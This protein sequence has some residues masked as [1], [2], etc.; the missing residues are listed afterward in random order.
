M[1]GDGELESCLVHL[2]RQTLRQYATTANIKANG[3]FECLIRQF[4]S[5]SEVAGK[6]GVPYKHCSHALK[7]AY[8]LRDDSDR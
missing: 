6:Y 7:K 1:V 8:T 4:P 5:A 2:L 3:I